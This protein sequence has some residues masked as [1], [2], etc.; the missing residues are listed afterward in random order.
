[1]SSYSSLAP[2]FLL[3]APIPKDLSNLGVWTP[4]HSICVYDVWTQLSDLS[5]PFYPLHMTSK[6][7]VIIGAKPHHHA[8]LANIHAPS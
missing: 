2:K 1:M 4:H 5:L 7:H 3:Q 6:G 8:D